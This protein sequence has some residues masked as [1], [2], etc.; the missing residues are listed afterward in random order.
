MVFIR[1]DAQLVVTEVHGDVEGLLGLS[2]ADVVGTRSMWRQFLTPPSFRRE[3]RRATT[4]ARDIALSEE[5]E[6]INRQSGETHWLLLKGVP[7]HN[8]HGEFTGWE[9]VG[10]DV[11]ERRRVGEE[12]TK[13]TRRVEAL[14]EVSRAIQVISDPASVT[15]K[16]LRAIVAATGSSCGLGCL[17]E[18]ATERLELVAAEGLSAT[19]VEGVSKILNSKTLA[20]LAFET[21][22]GFLIND[23]QNDSR[24]AVDLAKME[25][26]RSAIIVPLMSDDKAVG[27]LALFSRRINQYT[28]DDY[29]LVS[30]AARQIALAVRQADQYSAQRREADSLA[31]LY[32]LSH[33]LTKHLTPAEVAAHA[34]PIIQA[35]LA[36]RR[37]WLGILNDQGTHI[38]GQAGS[39]PGMRRSLTELQIDLA[40]SR[41]GLD[42][43]LRERIAVVVKPSD[44]GACEGFEKVLERL[45]VSQLILVPLV[46]LGQV[47]GVLIVEPTL[48][49]AVVPDRKL[50]LL[51]T[52]GSE[53]ATVIMARRF[54]A[55]MAESDKMRM[56]G[57][58]ASGVA[59]NFN[60]M[61]QAVMGQASLIEMQS[62][63]ESP[64]G[65]SAKMIIEAASKGATLI[66]QLMSFSMHGT[67]ARR[68][69]GLARLCADS[70][71]LYK[72]VLGSAI[73][74][75]IDIARDLPEIYADHNL[76]QQVIT[77]L[78][79]NARDAL[80]HRVDGAVTLRARA[81][82]LRSGE[83]DRELAPGEYVRLDVGDNGPGMDA[84]RAARCFEPFYTTKNVDART[85]VGLNGSGLG[86][87]SAYSIVRQHEGLITVRSQPGAGAV[88]S[89]Y[90]PLA[91]QAGMGADR[92]AVAAAAAASPVAFGE[93]EALLI[94]LEATV[95][96]AVKSTVQSLGMS[97]V[98]V[99]ERGEALSAVRDWSRGVQLV[100]IDI[101]TSGADVRTFI[102]EMRR[103]RDR[104]AILC[105]TSDR[106]RW[107]KDL[108]TIPGV[109][110]VEKP[111][112]VWTLSYHVRRALKSPLT[113]GLARRIERSA[114]SGEGAATPASE[115]S[116]VSA[117][118]VGDGE[119]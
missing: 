48:G 69:L 65:A 2:R 56:A 60:N 81:V 36:C 100:I 46:T 74:L 9:G 110:V 16:G 24:A 105:S 77:N 53:I 38:V 87:S 58:L 71:D 22:G 43:A 107:S 89:I 13:Q 6:V 44:A 97:A 66:K 94:N 57:V 47:V 1:T 80:A 27:A 88:F 90:L 10:I 7:H 63:R 51:T 92:A 103:A 67:S 114:V 54:E 85:G 21:S 42:R 12:V 29:E 31:A 96:L 41:P 20:R 70:A 50:K 116:N 82:T 35:E 83:I 18:A 61:L 112:G 73:D 15:L 40:V 11:T 109:E 104:I 23:L 25:G 113:T 101:D 33:E 19:Y 26:L 45:D 78:L 118:E 68:N 8:A 84:E 3:A 99:R 98:A 5:I 14:F 95:E 32:R 62:T 91:P 30:A 119:K 115:T 86:L 39:G 93:R 76:V 117:V 64:V 28:E 37:L 79:M 55:R 49:T 75:H 52:M 72:S 4:G 17:Y 106:V 102:M 108:A 111:L 34:F 59:H